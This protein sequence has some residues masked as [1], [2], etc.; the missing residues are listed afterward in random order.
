MKALR[1]RNINKPIFNLR[2]LERVLN[3]LPTSAKV[4]ASRYVRAGLLIRLKRDMYVLAEQW[5]YFSIEQKFQFANLIQTPSYISLMTALSYYH[6]STQIQR[7]FI[8]SIALKRTKQVNIE[9]TI[10]HYSKIK[11]DLYFGFVRQ[12]NF[13]IAEAEKALL[14]AFYLMSIKRYTLDVAAIDFGKFDR[15]KIASLLTKFPESVKQMV[16]EYELA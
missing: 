1:L 15:Q 7:D 4:I 14:D 6:I 13:F 12:R 8:E 9:K 5:P 3:V 10:F 11:S 2:D 16:A